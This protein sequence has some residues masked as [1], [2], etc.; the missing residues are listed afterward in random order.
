MHTIYSVSQY[1]RLAAKF[2]Y[3]S[4]DWQMGKK[5]AKSRA[6]SKVAPAPRGRRSEDEES[7]SGDLSGTSSET[8]RLFDT[9][10]ELR[11]AKQESL[12]LAGDI[13]E[14]DEADDDDA[15]DDDD[16]THTTEEELAAQTPP[17]MPPL[18]VPLTSTFRTRTDPHILLFFTVFRNAQIT[19]RI[20]I[21]CESYPFLLC[22]CFCST[23]VLTLHILFS[24]ASF[25]F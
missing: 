7:E 16:D 9:R 21:I 20:L 13:A 18:L 12:R 10:A 15:D 25:W 8:Q 5:K 3:C 1:Q 6:G 22:L 19:L 23:Y 2:S 17:P 24:L 14:D 4:C 11:E